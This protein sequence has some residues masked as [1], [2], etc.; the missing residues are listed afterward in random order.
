MNPMGSLEWNRP[1]PI[2]VKFQPSFTLHKLVLK[3]WSVLLIY[4]RLFFK[5]NI[6]I[7]AETGAAARNPL[8]V[9]RHSGTGL[10]LGRH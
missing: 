2:F 3:A 7:V 8:C 6:D 10:L 4:D 5:L 1:L 9:P